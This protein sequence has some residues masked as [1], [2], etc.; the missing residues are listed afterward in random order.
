MLYVQVYPKIYHIVLHASDVLQ[1]L[2][3][4]GPVD[5]SQLSARLTA[6]HTIR[7]PT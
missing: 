6:G 3:Q 5:I 7:Q 1:Q 4:Q 2:C